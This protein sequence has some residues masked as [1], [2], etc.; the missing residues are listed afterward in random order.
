MTKKTLAVCLG[1]LAAVASAAPAAAGPRRTNSAPGAYVD[2]DDSGTWSSGDTNLDAHFRKNGDYRAPS[3]G[4]SATADIV[5]TKAG[6][7]SDAAIVAGGNVLVSGRA[8]SKG[9]LYVIAPAGTI[10]VTNGGALASGD[11]VMNLRAKSI[12]LR[13]GSSLVHREEGNGLLAL[14]AAS[15]TIESGVSITSLVRD[16]GYSPDYKYGGVQI[17][18]SEHLDVADDLEI[19]APKSTISI[20]GPA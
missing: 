8:L 18:A 17:A 2:N 13:S 1:L 14:S 3:T 16:T 12:V 15:I 7:R 9:S 11:G 6:I 20:Q 4:R 10:E 5:I 19:N